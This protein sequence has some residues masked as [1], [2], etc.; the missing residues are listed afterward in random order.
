M[1]YAVLYDLNAVKIGCPTFERALET[2]EG[3]IVYTKLY[4]YNAKR[5]NDYTA[6]VRNRSA[7]VAV[8]LANRK[9]VR[10]D[11]R[12]VIDAIYLAASNKGIDAFFLIC[13]PIDAAP[14][15]HALREIGKRVVLGTL[16]PG[17]LDAECDAVVLL[18]REASC[19]DA[20]AQSAPSQVSP[21]APSDAQV[22]AEREDASPADTFLPYTQVQGNAAQMEP[23]SQALEEMIA[24][25]A[26]RKP[27]SEYAQPAVAIDELLKKYF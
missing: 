22:A 17:S 24:V 11:I 13:S 20:V 25:K 14:M 7:H 3:K 2:L 23:V 21:N 27:Q 9:K 5:N 8:P 19:S 10:V 16:S 12:Q 6:F 1:N 18:E 26:S 4:G 15:V